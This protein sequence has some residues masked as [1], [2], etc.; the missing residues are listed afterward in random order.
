M[1]NKEKKVALITNQV[2]IGDH[3]KGALQGLFDVDIYK[4][5][6]ALHHAMEKT[7]SYKAIITDDELL[8]ANG[9]PLRKTLDNFGYGQIPFMVIMDQIGLEFI[10]DGGEQASGSGMIK[11]ATNPIVLPPQAM[12]TPDRQAVDLIDDNGLR[13]FLIFRI[14][15]D[16]H[17]LNSAH[18]QG[19]GDMESQLLGTTE[20]TGQKLVEQQQNAHSAKHVLYS[21]NTDL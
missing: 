20:M 11:I 8:G 4:N 3:I 5:G 17:R 1:I 15:S 2:A 9:I 7:A 12:Q 10:Q 16:N 6:L 21:D 13:R 19:L 18:S 14:A